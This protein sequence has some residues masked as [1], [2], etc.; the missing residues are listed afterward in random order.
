MIPLQRR[1]RGVSGKS[2]ASELG[3][4][5][6]LWVLASHWVGWPD[7]GAKQLVAAACHGSPL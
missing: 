4:R 6:G 7:R 1:G 5:R 2:W 3:F